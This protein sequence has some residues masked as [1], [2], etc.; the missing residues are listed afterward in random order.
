MCISILKASLFPD[1]ESLLQNTG[2][3]GLVFFPKGKLFH[4]LQKLLLKPFFERCLV[5]QSNPKVDRYLCEESV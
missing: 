1:F 3:R 4:G 2:L 5:I